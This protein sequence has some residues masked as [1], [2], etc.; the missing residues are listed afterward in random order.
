M[1]RAGKLAVPRKTSFKPSAVFAL[2]VSCVSAVCYGQQGV[3][4]DANPT[5]PV[6]RDIEKRQQTLPPSPD[7]VNVQEKRRAVKPVPGLKTDVKA[8][9][10]TGLTVVSEA[11]LQAEVK[12]Y[13]GPDK[14]FDDL[15][16]AADAVSEYLQRKGY[17]VGQA[18]LP[19]QKIDNGIVE[20]AVLEGR[21]GQVRVDMDDNVRV[22]RS[23]IEGLLTPL[24]P[25]TVLHRDVVE[26]S[27]FLVSDLRGLTVRS[28][29]EPGSVPGTSNIVLKIAAAKLVD[30]T[31]E[32]DNHTSRF[33]GD[34]RLGGSVNINSPFYRGDLLSFR[35]LLGI[36]NGGA[37]QDF[38]RIS[39]LTPIGNYGSKIGLAYLRLNYRIGTELFSGAGLRGRSEV[40][41]LFGLHPIVRTRNLNL[42]AQAAYDMRDFTDERRASASVS[43]RDTKVLGLS[44]VGDSRD[45]FLGGG[46][47][48]FSFGTTFGDLDINTPA[49]LAADLSAAGHNTQGRYNRINFS[50][51]R[52]NSLFEK[53]VAFVSYSYQYASKNLDASEKIGLG[54]PNGVRAYAVGEA[55]SDEAHL[56]TAEVRRTLPQPSFMPGSLVGLAF[57][58]WA[59]GRVNKNPLALEIPINQ[60]TLS[61]VGLGL[62]W[63]RTEDFLVRT[64]LAWRLTGSPISDP[65]DKKPR[66]FFQLQKNL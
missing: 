4:A 60:R 30:G 19:E 13:L 40:K 10:F 16:S 38:G 59:H 41:S 62:T 35:G 64:T 43:E 49:V 29:V 11:E 23:M 21:L 25:G 22:S 37:D 57:F 20:I 9:R 52:L 18:F 28:I 14:T 34:A 7:G 27:L 58:D 63:T 47:N 39:Y 3:P 24:K 17:I 53:T 1:T 12:S 26:R 6:L 66:F 8:F 50:A 32:L 15:Q 56:F 31:V 2:A 45:A 44:L 5:A 51:S 54:G 46:I 33:T 42:F 65:E 61:G 36:P 48:N 55:T